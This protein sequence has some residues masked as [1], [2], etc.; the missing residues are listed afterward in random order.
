LDP[1]GLFGVEHTD[2]DPLTEGVVDFQLALG[3]DSNNDGILTDPVVPPLGIDEYLGNQA[4]ELVVPL[5]AN[6]NGTWNVAG[7]LPQYRTIR[8][9]LLVRTESTYVGDANLAIALPIENYTSAY[10]T[11]ASSAQ[12]APRYRPMRVVVAPRIWN[13]RN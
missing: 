12:G 4:G 6:A 2:A 8:A 5:P 3:S 9:T 11:I 10:P 1:N 7:L 13:L